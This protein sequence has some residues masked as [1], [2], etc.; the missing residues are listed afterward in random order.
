MKRNV[1]FTPAARD[2]LAEIWM[3]AANRQQVTDAAN[4]IERRLAADAMNEG[5]SRDGDT[6]ISMVAPLAALFEVQEDDSYV[7][8][9]RFWR[10]GS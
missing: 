2:A 6:R 4:E 8:V 9:I 7:K 3:A 10:F 1:I 5:E